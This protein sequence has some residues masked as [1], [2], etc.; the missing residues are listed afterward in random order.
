MTNVGIQKIY[1]KILVKGSL[2]GFVGRARILDLKIVS[3]ST[4]L[5]IEIIER[6][7]KERKKKK[8]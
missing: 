1:Y 5:G 3:S 2:A 6:K 8:V 7:G 4:T